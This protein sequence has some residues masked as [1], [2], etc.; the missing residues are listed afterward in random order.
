MNYNVNELKDMLK[1]FNPE[2][3][4]DEDVDNF[5]S[6]LGLVNCVPEFNWEFGATKCVIIP[7][8]RDFVIKI[9][10]DGEI[11]YEDSEEGDFRYYYNGG[12]KEGWDYCE[13]ENEY[14]A[15][16][17]EGSEF[18]QFFLRPEAIDVNENWPIYI[19]PKVVP[20]NENVKRHYLDIDSIHRVRT[21]SKMF[22][23]VSLPDT[24]LATCLE[25]LNNNIEKLDEFIHFIKTNF[26]DLHSGNL[27]YLGNQA[28]IL[29]Y[30]GF[31]D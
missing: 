8:N 9:P 20:C 5:V 1:F 3:F 16:L 21:E 4:T 31:A 26:S 11:T 6:E 17:I 7:E 14:W 30:A 13:L 19:Q 24:W 27:G 29:D 28:V 10:F 12:G 25:N 23:Q 22:K 2:H 15:D 18:K